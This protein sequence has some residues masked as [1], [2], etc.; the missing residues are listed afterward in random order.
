MK[1]RR[2]LF[3]TLAL[4]TLLASCTWSCAILTINLASSTSSREANEP[5]TLFPDT[6]GQGFAIISEPTEPTNSPTLEKFI[7]SSLVALYWTICFFPF[8]LIFTFLWRRNDIGWQQE[9]RHQEQLAEIRELR[10]AINQQNGQIIENDIS[11]G[12]SP[13]LMLSAKNYGNS[14]APPSPLHRVEIIN[15]KE[16]KR[17]TPPVIV[18][19]PLTKSDTSRYA[20]PPETDDEKLEKAAKMWN[21]GRR[22]RAIEILE[23]MPKNPKAREILKKIRKQLR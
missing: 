2:N 1:I 14:Y 21:L 19:P 20:P 8:F 11:Q 10:Y 23:S 3:G 4:L 12:Y 7:A 22:G 13:P 18:D 9:R 5:I 16:K 15:E 6:S 17:Y